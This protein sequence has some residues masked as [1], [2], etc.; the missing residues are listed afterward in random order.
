MTGGQ[1]HLLTY[2]GIWMSL[3]GELTDFAGFGMPYMYVFFFFLLHF[4]LFIIFPF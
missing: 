3:S 4:F 1:Q 2:I